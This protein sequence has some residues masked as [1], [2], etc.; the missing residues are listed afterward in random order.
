LLLLLVVVLLVLQQQQPL[1]TLLGRLLGKQH[2][3]CCHLALQPP[4]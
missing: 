4:N 2:Y 3:R 1:L